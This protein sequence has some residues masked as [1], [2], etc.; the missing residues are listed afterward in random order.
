M[1]TKKNGKK[2]TGLFFLPLV[3]SVPIVAVMALGMVRFW[4]EIHK[5]LSIM[6]KLGVK[7]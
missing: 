1:S 5:L 4:P 7:A 6:I 2:G 3:V